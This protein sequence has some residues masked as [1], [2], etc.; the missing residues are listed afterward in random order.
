VKLIWS[1]ID[2]WTL[3]RMRCIWFGTHMLYVYMQLLCMY[4]IGYGY[5]FM[6]LVMV[7]HE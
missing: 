4:H 7:M 3:T 5:A 1:C 6:V 2:D